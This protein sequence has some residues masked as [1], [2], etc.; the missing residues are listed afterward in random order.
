MNIRSEKTKKLFVK[1]MQ[2]HP[3]ERFWQSIRNFSG[4]PFIVGSNVA[5]DDDIKLGDQEDT[6]YIEEM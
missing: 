5:P 3:E 4:Y 2:E 1:Y 6:F